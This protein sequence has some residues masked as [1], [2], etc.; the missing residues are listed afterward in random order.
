MNDISGY[1][2]TGSLYFFKGRPN[3]KTE[4]EKESG[5]EAGNIVVNGT[6]A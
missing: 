5:A 3:L 2:S 1:T 4:I 6:H